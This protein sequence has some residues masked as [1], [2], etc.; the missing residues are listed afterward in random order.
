MSSLGAGIAAGLGIAMPVGAIGTYLVGLGAS[1]PARVSTAAA[2]GVASTDGLYAAVAVTAGAALEAV[3]RPAASWL[4][5]IS[6]A[7]LC[8]LAVL[9]LVAAM[10]RADDATMV[11][12]RRSPAVTATPVRAYLVLLGLTG[13]NPATL[14]YFT[15]LV[16]GR[17]AIGTT[18]TLDRITFVAGAFAA[19]L[20]WQL[21]L[22]RGGALLGHLAQ[23]RRGRLAIAV[24]SSAVMLALAAQVAWR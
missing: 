13:L 20:A 3:L 18:T 22:T 8:L 12:V 23:G 15:S 16:L 2:A 17:Q 19:S 1:A 9:T 6:V 4:R 21:A 10:R 11:G 5:W 24:V 14:T 7:V